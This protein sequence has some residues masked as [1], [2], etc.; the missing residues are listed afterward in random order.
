MSEAIA[1]QDRGSETVAETLEE[2]V[3]EV[4]ELLPQQAPLHAF[5]HHNTL[6]HFEHLPFEDAVIEA[7]TVLGTESF[8]SESAFAEHLR[9]GRILDRDVESVLDSRLRAAP[10]DPQAPIFPGGPSLRAFRCFRLR[11]LFEIPYGATLRWVLKEGGAASSVHPSVPEARRKAIG[12]G[13]SEALVL[14][15]LWA[16]LDEFAPLRTPP[17]PGPRP[18]DRLL[19]ATELDTDEWVHPLLIRVSAAFLDQGIAYWQMPDRRR[20]F[21]SA[22]RRLYGRP[23]SPSFLWARGLD[24]T[25]AEQERRRW[26]ATTTVGWALD[27]LHVRREDWPEVIQATLLSLRGWAGMMRHLEERPDRAPVVSPPASLMEFLAVELVLD[28]FATRHV[29]RTRSD[30]DLVD[31]E[32]RIASVSSLPYRD[33]SLVFEA[34]VLA[35]LSDLPLA[36]FSE[37]GVAEGWME[38]VRA[39]DSIE[40]R[41]IL[42]LAYER[43]HRV[44]VLDALHARSAHPA[45]VGRPAVPAESPGFQAVFCIDDREESLRRHLEEIDPRVETF[46]YAGFFGVAMEYQGLDDIRSRPLCPVVIQPVHRVS[47]VAASPE[48]HASYASKRRRRGH[49]SLAVS[50]GVRTLVRGGLM[51][52]I[53]GPLSTVSLVGRAAFPRLAHAVSHWLA[54][55]GVERPATRLVIEADPEIDIGEALRV[56]FTLDEMTD[57]VESALR[58][59]ALDPA[60]SRL[61]L[62]VGHGSSSLNNPHEAAHDCGATGGG[63]GGPNARAFAQ[64]ANHPGVRERLRARGLSIPD[65]TRFLGAYHNTCD[66]TMTYYDEDLIEGTHGADLVAAKRALAEACARDAHERCRRFESAPLTIAVEDALED[67]HEHSVD[68]AQPRPEYGH[69]TNAVCIVGRR[70]RTRGLFLDRRAFLV[71]YDPDEDPDGRWLGPLLNSVGPV[72]AGINLEYYFSFVD[73]TGY[74]SGTKLPH[75]IVALLGVMNGHSSDLRTGL[76]WQMVEIHEPVRLLT[77]VDARREVLE[78]ILEQNAALRRLIGNQWIQ[79]VCWDPDSDRFHVFEEGGFVEYQP[80]SD[81]VATAP[82]SI[83]YY[84]GHREHLPPAW[85]GDG[86]RAGC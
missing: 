32:G 5:V 61:V 19:A 18:R 8:Q 64:M 45:R 75:N 43:R 48:A 7:S 65:G 39:F 83:E 77:I 84:R 20:G 21:L 71:S 72:G 60:R 3:S 56:G 81:R 47:E 54:G 74:G 66:D 67:A 10:E 53:L 13:G 11:H 79:F 1:L 73:P 68:L 55:L 42:H 23:R 22:F 52:S 27:A 9:S 63:R 35:Q 30:M 25:L 26:N 59:M 70:S 33:R 17:S 4:A 14:A 44:E 2:I 57:I 62:I 34:Y 12:Q 40:R 51:S 41:R 36:R 46:G 6:H 31:A 58:T 78:R 85:I 76:P 86:G 24:R 82:S 38:A 29:L 69:A 37:A 80:E 16:S 49:A 50:V 15:R 28:V